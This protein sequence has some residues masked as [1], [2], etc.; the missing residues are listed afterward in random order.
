MQY[1]EPQTALDAWRAARSLPWSPWSACPGLQSFHRWSLAPSPPSWGTPGGP[2]CWAGSCAE[3]SCHS[4]EP[5]GS[6]G[7]P[8]AKGC[9]HIPS[10]LLQLISC[11]V[12]FTVLMALKKIPISTYTINT[13]TNKLHTHIIYVDVFVHVDN[14]FPFWMHLT[15]MKAC[16]LCV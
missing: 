4:A 2:P 14:K 3:C 6:S 11:Y 1:P 9:Q 12:E 7:S 8:E 5:R 16:L 10:C 15:A 13:D